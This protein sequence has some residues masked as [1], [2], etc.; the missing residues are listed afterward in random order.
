MTVCTP[1]LP[2]VA[3]LQPVLTAPRPHP[4]HPRPSLPCPR[5]CVGAAPLRVA[6]RVG[7]SVHPQ[8]THIRDA[9]LP[10]SR[11]LQRLSRRLCSRERGGVGGT[12]PRVAG[13]SPRLLALRVMRAVCRS[14]LVRSRTA[15]RAR[16]GGALL[17]QTCMASGSM[18]ASCRAACSAPHRRCGCRRA[19][20]RRLPPPP[21]RQ[22]PPGQRSSRP[23][24]SR[25]SWASAMRMQEECRK[26]AGF[27]IL[28][29]HQRARLR[30]PAGGAAP[31]RMHTGSVLP[32][33]RHGRAQQ[34]P[35]C[36]R[37]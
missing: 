20:L 2:A 11:R 19:P 9:Q 32:I 25:G 35:H 7:D 31:S 33:S 4:I 28:R 5:A 34:C 37:S 23:A 26:D 30:W 15:M 16:D 36:T 12:S 21:P 8:V 18:P 14:W 17:T 22:R 6:A 24:H 13:L 10:G 3:A 29:D 27:S 1:R